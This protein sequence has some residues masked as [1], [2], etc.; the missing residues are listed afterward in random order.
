MTEQKKKMELV[1]LNVSSFV[2]ITKPS[3]N[4]TV[5]GGTMSLTNTVWI[6]IMLEYGED[7]LYSS[8]VEAVCHTD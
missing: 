5:Q 1:E 4:K 3:A 7:I 8:F 6:N 2:T